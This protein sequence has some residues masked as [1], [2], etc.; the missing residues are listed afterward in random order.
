MEAKLASQQ[1]K[2]QVAVGKEELLK[3][4]EESLSSRQTEV[5]FFRFSFIIF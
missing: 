4:K 5:R 2:L 3:G 1:D